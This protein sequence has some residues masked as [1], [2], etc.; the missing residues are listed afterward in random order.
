M[1]STFFSTPS[2][3]FGVFFCLLSNI[4]LA[5]DNFEFWPNAN[6]DPLIPSIE[7]VLGY[8]PGEKITWHRDVIKYFEALAQVA[9][10]RVVLKEYA[11]SWQDRELI[12]A[13]ISSPQNLEKIESVKVG[14]QRLS[15]PRDTDERSAANI[16][17]DQ[18]AVT[19]L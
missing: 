10:D 18:P 11:R 9:P 5:Q 19:W 17:P 6:Y 2:L 1:K 13:V 16:I 12:Y 14:M 7:D 3:F 15:D 4:A 8:S